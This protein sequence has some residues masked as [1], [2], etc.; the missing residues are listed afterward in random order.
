MTDTTDIKAL[1]GEVPEITNLFDAGKF[2]SKVLDLLEAERQRLELVR[3][4]RDNELRTNSQLEAELAALRE[5]Y[6]NS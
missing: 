3:E 4:Q 6:E 5:K 2:I 1:R